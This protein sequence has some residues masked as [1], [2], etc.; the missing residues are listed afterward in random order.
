MEM[1]PQSTEHHRDGLPRRYFRIPPLCSCFISLCSK[2][3]LYDWRLTLTKHSS[4]ALH[5]PQLSFRFWKSLKINDSQ[6]KHHFVRWTKKVTKLN[7]KINNL[8]NRTYSKGNCKTSTTEA[9]LV[10]ELGIS[11]S[12]QTVLSVNQWCIDWKQSVPS[13][14]RCN[15]VLN[16]NMATEKLFTEEGTVETAF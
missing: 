2:Y 7:S 1:M 12:T 3:V 8:L 4:F 15:L 14:P 6:N 11:D 13:A 10:M 9:P 16:I 5:N